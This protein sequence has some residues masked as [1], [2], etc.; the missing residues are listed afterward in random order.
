MTNST[1]QILALWNAGNYTKA[2]NLAKEL[3]PV[4]VSEPNLAR[5]VAGCYFKLSEFSEALSILNSLESV[6]YNDVE[7]LSLYAATARRIGDFEKS[8]QLFEHALTIDS[9]SLALK[10]N[11]ANLLID[12][13]SFEKAKQ[14]LLEILSIDPAFSDATSNLNRLNYILTPMSSLMSTNVDSTSSGF[15]GFSLS[16]PL[17]MAFA[18]AEIAHAS[19]RYALN[20]PEKDDVSSNMPAPNQV[21]SAHEQI[22][23]A[24]QACKNGQYDFALKLCSQSLLTYGPSAEIYDCASDI[25]LNLRNFFHS[26]ICLLHSL[27]LGGETPKRLLNLVSFSAM[28][29][30]IALAKTYLQKAASLDPSHPQLNQV[31][32]SVKQSSDVKPFDF[33][34]PWSNSD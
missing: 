4:L 33:R 31:T 25:Y 20:K 28:R 34:A 6:F 17:L 5:I 22:V 30:D 19:K 18:D 15:E 16:D 24:L 1:N 13:K 14:I 2:I 12:L 8:K 3:S 26:E 29:G 27:A 9:Q 32:L 7:F 23:L 21:S 10:N 11:Y